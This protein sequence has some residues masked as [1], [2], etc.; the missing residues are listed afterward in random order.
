MVRQ[1]FYVGHS[2]GGRE[3]FATFHPPTEE[4]HGGRYTAATG[5]FRTRRG[6]EWAA[7]CRYGWYGSIREAE[8]LA[9]AGVSR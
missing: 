3:M 6:A 1:R 7:S 9:A 2:E 5:P 8:R 4:S